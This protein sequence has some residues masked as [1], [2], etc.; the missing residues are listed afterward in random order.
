MKEEDVLTE[1]AGVFD[2][3]TL[4]AEHLL[5]TQFS[6]EELNQLVKEEVVSES[7][8]LPKDGSS[9]VLQEE[10][11]Q[12][13]NLLENEASAINENSALIDSHIENVGTQ[14]VDTQLKELSPPVPTEE[15]LK[16]I[17]FFHLFCEDFTIDA[18]P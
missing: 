6:Q 10:D 11:L 9:P 16:G 3:S 8:L 4:L 14:A 7:I 2:D 18:N 17:F 1:I 15:P 5:D 13:L 12:Y